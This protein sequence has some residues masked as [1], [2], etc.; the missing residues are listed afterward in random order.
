LKS[1]NTAIPLLTSLFFSGSYVAAKYTTSDLGPLT[2]SFLRYAVALLFLCCLLFRSKRLSLKIERKDIFLLFI[3][4]LSGIVGYH[5]FFLLALRYTQVANT[6]IINAAS[7]ILTALTAAL[8]IG[9]RLQSK[10]YAGILLAFLGV[11]ILLARG[12][13]NN[14]LTLNVNI[15]DAIMLLATLSWVIYAL[16]VKKLVTKY[17]SFVITFFATLFGVVLLFFLALSENLVDQI[18]HVSSSSVYAILYMGICASG[19]GY[20]LYN[21]SI[22]EIGPTRTSS[23]VYSLVPVLV[24]FLS[25][26]FFRQTITFTMISSMGLILIG[27]RFMLKE[28]TTDRHS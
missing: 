28:N 21:L 18:R 27:L 22:R 10:N 14:L 5:Y 15:G 9:E 20:L 16:I 2:T 6:A 11:V 8:F 26:F 1:K 24:S 23:F 7:P 4:G 17:S 12:S 19:L 13:V 25:L 3:L